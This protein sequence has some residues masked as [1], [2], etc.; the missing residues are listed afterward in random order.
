M[1]PRRA[2][3]AS[4]NS[5]RVDG[6]GLC[7]SPRTTAHG[8]QPQAEKHRRRGLGHDPKAPIEYDVPDAL[9]TPLQH[10]V[11]SVY[12]L[13]EVGR[14]EHAQGNVAVLVL[15]EGVSKRTLLRGSET[16]TS[17]GGANLLEESVITECG[18]QLRFQDRVAIA[19]EA[20]WSDDFG[21]RR[22]LCRI[23]VLDAVC[24][25][26][27]FGVGRGAIDA[28]SIEVERRTLGGGRD[29]SQPHK[30]N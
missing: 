22:Y 4:M 15:V 13:R 25:E 2:D 28:G 26:H 14:S 6:S 5:R 1:S 9:R 27:F 3:P 19:L 10:D 12:H 30:Y 23:D 20:A 29:P 24:A 8:Q 7:L 11:L 17:I 21:T 16:A 18:R